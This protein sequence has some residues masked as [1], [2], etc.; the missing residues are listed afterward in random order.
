MRSHALSLSTRQQSCCAHKRTDL[1]CKFLDS[2]KRSGG[3][4]YFLAL[5]QR[6]QLART[7]L[8]LCPRLAREQHLQLFGCKAPAKMLKESAFSRA[9]G[10][11]IA[12]C[13]VRRLVADM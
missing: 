9:H 2:R 11:S 8:E 12:Q 5:A 7:F 4:C 3:R 1:F 6:I 10:V 13:S